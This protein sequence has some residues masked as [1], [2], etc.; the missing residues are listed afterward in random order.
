MAGK[1][2]D[3]YRIDR[4]ETRATDHKPFPQ[5]S[6]GNSSLNDTVQDDRQRMAQGQGEGRGGQ[7]FL[8][9]VPSPSAEANRAAQ[10]EQLEGESDEEEES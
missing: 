3:Q 10:R 4:G 7:P 6:Q 1:R 9:D 8:P 2:P 5:T